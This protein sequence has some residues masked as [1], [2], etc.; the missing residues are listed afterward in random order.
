MES[1][2][3]IKI[4]VDITIHPKGGSRSE[5]AKALVYQ[6][7]A[8][9]VSEEVGAAKEHSNDNYVM[10]CAN[11]DYMHFKLRGIEAPSVIKVPVTNIGDLRV[12]RIVTAQIDQLDGSAYDKP[13][14]CWYDSD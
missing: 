2:Y 3:Y 8:Q 10:E 14:T 12:L 5:P 1:N 11:S 7:S 13:G 9:T 4:E 6:M